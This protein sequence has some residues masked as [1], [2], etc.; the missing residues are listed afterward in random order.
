MQL[1]DVAELKLTVVHA[2]PPIVTVAPFI[3]LEPV[4]V[5]EVP[6]ANGPVDGVT[7]EIVGAGAGVTEFEAEEADEVPPTLVAVTVKV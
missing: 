6:P 2:T 7:V 5:I 1:I 3:K 4:I